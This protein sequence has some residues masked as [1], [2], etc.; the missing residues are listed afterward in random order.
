[1]N[2]PFEKLDN[3]IE[4]K[5]LKREKIEQLLER[6]GTDEVPLDEQAKAEIRRDLEGEQ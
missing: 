4:A 6:G 5:R 2:N 3:I 1:M